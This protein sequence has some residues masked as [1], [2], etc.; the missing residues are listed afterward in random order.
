VGRAAC[1]RRASALVAPQAIG[2]A[3]LAFDLPLGVARSVLLVP[4]V[5]SGGVIS[6]G[7]G[8]LLLSAY[9]GYLGVLLLG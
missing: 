6:R 3:V 1:E 8:A 7:E 2:P 5:R 9:A 4:V